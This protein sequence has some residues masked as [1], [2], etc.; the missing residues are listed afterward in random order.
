MMPVKCL[1]QDLK[2]VSAIGIS[3]SISISISIICPLT[4]VLSNDTT[5]VQ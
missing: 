3:I 2:V 5:V 1:A 4:C